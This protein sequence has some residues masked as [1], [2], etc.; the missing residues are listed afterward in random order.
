MFSVALRWAYIKIVPPRIKRSYKRMQMK[1]R[2]RPMMSNQEIQILD[3][4]LSSPFVQSVLEIGCGGSTVYF[5]ARHRVEW[6]SV[7]FNASWYRD[8]QKLVPNN[9]ELYL[10]EDIP[11][12][13][14]KFSPRAKEFQVVL[15][16]GPDDHREW[17]IKSVRD[18]DTD[19]IVLVH[20]SRRRGYEE[21]LSTY[22]RCVHLTAGE[23]PRPGGG[24]KG[25]G[26]SLLMSVPPN[27]P[28]H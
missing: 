26:L 20:D 13:I 5:P 25:R 14:A 2:P 27:V 9:V 12:F 7:E 15:I 3:N 11:A 6:H 17:V 1:L 10:L 28:R 16:D 18:W 4:I 24:C 22:F 19:A 8:I 21:A 23:F